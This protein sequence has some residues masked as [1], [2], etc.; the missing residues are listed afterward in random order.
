MIDD[1]DGDVVGM[2]NPWVDG[3]VDDIRFI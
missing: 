2:D 1:R 3:I